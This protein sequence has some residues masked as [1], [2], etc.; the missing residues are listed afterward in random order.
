[1]LINCQ[2]WVI[3]PSNPR[4]SNILRQLP[5]L[6]ERTQIVQKSTHKLEHDHESVLF[7][8][9]AEELEVESPVMHPKPVKNL[10]ATSLKEIEG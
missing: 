9:L 2:K 3:E 5:L 8:Q 6:E 1:M 10:S 4:T 7:A